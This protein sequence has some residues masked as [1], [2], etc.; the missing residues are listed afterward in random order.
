MLGKGKSTFYSKVQKYRK[1]LKQIVFK[2]G[3]K[4]VL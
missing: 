1:Y 3:I 2:K 4:Q